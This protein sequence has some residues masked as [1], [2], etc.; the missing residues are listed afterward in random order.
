MIYHAPDFDTLSVNAYFSGA[1][2]TGVWTNFGLRA[3]AR[4]NQTQ[5]TDEPIFAKYWRGGGCV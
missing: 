3:R 5:P 4:Q 2:G 1:F